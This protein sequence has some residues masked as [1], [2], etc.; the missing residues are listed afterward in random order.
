MAHHMRGN[1]TLS[2]LSVFRVCDHPYL[3]TKCLF[4]ANLVSSNLNDDVDSHFY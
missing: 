1:A 2:S 4:L 3:Y